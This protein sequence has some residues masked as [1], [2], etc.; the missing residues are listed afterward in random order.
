MYIHTYYIQSVG[1]S[2]C[3]FVQNVSSGIYL[4][5]C[6]N[7]G[8]NGGRKSVN[9]PSYLRNLQNFYLSYLRNLHLPYIYIRNARWYSKCRGSLQETEIHY[10][11]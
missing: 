1:L 10:I 3:I 8:G 6:V 4:R 9:L 5:V 2:K 7:Y 11:M